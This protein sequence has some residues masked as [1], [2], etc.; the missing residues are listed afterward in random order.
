LI[1]RIQ[2]FDLTL[3]I[4]MDVDHGLMVPTVPTSLDVRP[5]TRVAAS[6]DSVRSVVITRQS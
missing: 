1:R 2:D 6:S 3:I 4:Q 5:T